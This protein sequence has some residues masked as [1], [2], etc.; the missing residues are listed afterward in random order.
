MELTPGSI[1]KVEFICCEK[2]Q[3]TEMFSKMYNGNY[4]CESCGHSSHNASSIIIDISLKKYIEK[5][6]K[7]MIQNELS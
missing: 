2:C 5:T 7:E 1:V 4:R 6:A 3:E